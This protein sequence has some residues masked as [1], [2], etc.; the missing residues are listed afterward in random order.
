MTKKKKR[1][2]A[3][4][5]G[6]IVFRNDRPYVYD[7]KGNY[8]GRYLDYRMRRPGTNYLQLMTTRAKL[9]LTK[10]QRAHLTWCDKQGK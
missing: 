6:H 3:W 1:I 7:T 9:K 5:P 2:E 4:R 10:A 8:K